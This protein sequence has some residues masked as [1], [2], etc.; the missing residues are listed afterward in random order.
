MIFYTKVKVKVNSF[1]SENIPLRR[2]VRQGYPV[3]PLLY[4]LI[5]EIL[6]L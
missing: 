5:I 4:V 2:G 3:S 1:L 6:A